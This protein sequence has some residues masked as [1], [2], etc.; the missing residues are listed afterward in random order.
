[1]LKFL[2][3]YYNCFLVKLKIRKKFQAKENVS[4]KAETTWQPDL[5]KTE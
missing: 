1:M 3:L 5:F 2:R 4:G